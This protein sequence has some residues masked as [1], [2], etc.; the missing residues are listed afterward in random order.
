MVYLELERHPALRQGLFANGTVE[1]GRATAFAVPRS[2]VRLDQSRPYVLVV[3]GDRIAQ[4]DVQLG[5]SGRAAV[6]GEALVAL[7]SGVSEGATL[8]A[9]SLGTVRD[10]TPVRLTAAADAASASSSP[11]SANSSAAKR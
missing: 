6:G 1:L 9:G 2:S 5:T 8:L 11:T 7:Q 10:G 4:R 3:E